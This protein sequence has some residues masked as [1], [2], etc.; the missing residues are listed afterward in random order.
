MNEIPKFS[1]SAEEASMSISPVAKC[2][3]CNNHESE[4]YCSKEAFLIFK[5]PACD[6]EYVTNPPSPEELEN[7]YS[8]E[9]YYQGGETEGYENYDE[10]TEESIEAIRS[11]LESYSDKK[12]CILDIG[13]GYG[14]HLAIAASMGWQCSGVELSAHARGVAS[15]RLGPSVEIAAKVDDIIPCAFDIVLMLDVVEHVSD[16]YSLFYP[17]FTSGSIHQDTLVIITTPNAGSIK[18]KT[19][20]ADW[21]YRH[22]PSHLTYFTK[23]SLETLFDIMQ[24][25]HIEVEGIHPT[26]DGRFTDLTIEKHAGLLLKASGSDCQSF[27]QKRHESSIW[28]N[29]LEVY[30]RQMIVKDLQERIIESDLMLLS[31]KQTISAQEQH[32]AILASQLDEVASLCS[33][34]E[35][36]IEM[37]KRSRWYR[38]GQKVRAAGVHKIGALEDT[39]SIAKSIQERVSSALRSL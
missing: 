6:L 28:S 14:S 33:E 25:A 34:L 24:F 7:Y 10:Q 4:P 39:S 18:A 29:Y 19:E 3:I 23:K 36:S 32:L 5:C 1:T 20:L 22:P 16:P 8:R 38:L 21:I 12:G 2:P 30:R 27:I 26:E 9:E 35:Q 11:L 13:C 15:E 17:L 37:H 31:S